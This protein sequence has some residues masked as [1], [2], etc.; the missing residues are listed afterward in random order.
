ME[1][2]EKKNKIN[3]FFFFNRLRHFDMSASIDLQIEQPNKPLGD[4]KTKHDSF[5]FF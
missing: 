4:P 3:F 5:F 1:R 2:N